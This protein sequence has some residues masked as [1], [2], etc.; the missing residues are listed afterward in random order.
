[1]TDS[2]SGLI[3]QFQSALD[4]KEDLQS[5]TD[6]E[7]VEMLMSEALLSKESLAAFIS[8][9]QLEQGLVERCLF[10]NLKL[11]SDEALAYLLQEKKVDLT[12]TQDGK[13]LVHLL[14]EQGPLS[15]LKLVESFTEFQEQ[16]IKGR[17]CL[18]FAVCGSQADI[19]L[20]LLESH[21]QID[22]QDYDAQ[23]P[24]VYAIKQ[25]NISVVKML[26][27]RGASPNQVSESSPLPVILACQLGDKEIL[28]ALFQKGAD[29]KAGEDGLLPLH[30]VSRL[31]FS[32][33]IE[34]C[35]KYGSI[36]ET[37]PSGWTPL[38]YAANDG[39]PDCVRLLLE[40]GAKRDIKDEQGWMPRTWAIWN[41]YLDVAE[42][43]GAND[44]PD[45]CCTSSRKKPGSTS[46][47]DDLDAIPDLSLP[48]PIIPLRIYG[49]SYLE[50]KFL[51]QIWFP[52]SPL[53]MSR[54][55]TSCRLSL[56]VNSQSQ[57][58]HLPLRDSREV[59]QFLSDKDV[60][61][62]VLVKP[63][64]G[65]KI[66]AR[67]RMSKLKLEDWIRQGKEGR[68][69]IP[70]FGEGAEGDVQAMM[71][72][73][74]PFEFQNEKREMYW[75]AKGGDQMLSSLEKLYLDVHVRFSRDGKAVVSKSG[76]VVV[77]PLEIPVEALSEEELRKVEKEKDQIMTVIERGGSSEEVIR[78]LVLPLKSSCLLLDELLRVWKSF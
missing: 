39:Q 47:L 41:G 55:L 22:C 64:F 10:K 21:L 2:V 33:L 53:K 37:C 40:K 4:D 56:N 76:V 17:S 59:Y 51:V 11:V 70:V 58:I 45:T 6:Q 9:R 63:V 72:V 78:S 66:V 57:D 36:E 48:P 12:F 7:D 20:Y 32:D 1:M 74:R 44:S 26:L 50:G 38:F 42:I 25:K 75:R 8:S 16:D 65:S 43:L 77:G 19:I 15:R 60:E 71:S 31:G 35:L 24:L 68:I 18:H 62:S 29:Y 52:G 34:P 3:R 61:F 46:T 69:S 13:Y 30:I 49:H 67:G 5:E 54:P 14:S 28:Q 73:I 23:T 27:N